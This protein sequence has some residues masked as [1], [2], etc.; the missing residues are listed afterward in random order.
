[1]L[2]HEIRQP[3]PNFVGNVITVPLSVRKDH[4]PLIP[5]DF[6]VK[7]FPFILTARHMNGRL[8]RK[9]LGYSKKRSMLEAACIW[10]DVVYNFA[11]PVKTLRLE[12]NEDCPAGCPVLPAWRQALLTTSESLKNYCLVS[13]SPPTHLRETRG[14]RVVMEKRFR[15]R[16]HSNQY[17]ADGC[18]W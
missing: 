14:F 16:F 15:K 3:G 11:R 6:I 2:S 18:H 4:P 12:V 13:Q 7:L 1:M 10:E 8:V 17:R 5:L 9:T